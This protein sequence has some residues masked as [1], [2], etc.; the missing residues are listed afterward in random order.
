[1]RFFGGLLYFLG[2]ILMVIN[3]LQLQDK[4][5]SKKKFLLKLLHLQKLEMQEK[6]EKENT[7]G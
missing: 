2:A 5:L 3:L 4:V 7:F 1:M 6:K